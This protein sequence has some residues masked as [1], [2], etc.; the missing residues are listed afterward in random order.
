MG[1]L[2]LKEE[3]AIK[4]LE[5]AMKA[6]PKTIQLYVVDGMLTICKKGGSS[7][8]FQHNILYKLQ[9]TV[10]LD[11]ARIEDGGTDMY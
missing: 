6:I 1:E 3:T 5:K 8:L 10:A 2:T 4:N 7:R 9:E 11:D